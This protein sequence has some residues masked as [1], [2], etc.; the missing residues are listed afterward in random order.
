MFL[1]AVA[2]WVLELIIIVPTGLLGAMQNSAARS[3]PGS[4]G[5]W[6]IFSLLAPAQLG[7]F[8]LLGIALSGGMY[9][10]LGGILKMALKQVRGEEI[11]LADILSV[12]DVAMPL[13]VSGLIISIVGSLAMQVFVLPGIVVYALLMFT[14]LLIVDQ[15]LGAIDAIKA[16]V[17]MLKSQWLM[18]SVFFFVSYLVACLGAILCGI[19]MLATFPVFLIS[20]AYGYWTFTGSTMSV[21]GQPNYGVAQPGVWPPPPGAGNAASFG[22][23]GAGPA[24]GQTPSAPASTPDQTG[25]WPPAQPAPEP[26]QQQPGAWPPTQ[27]GAPAEPPAAPSP[28]EWPAQ[29]TP[30]P[31]GQTPPEDPNR[32]LGGS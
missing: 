30:P 28:S 4:M 8:F 20:I 16:S 21:A 25:A 18:A 27:S 12:G 9:I 17:D 2:V 26:P 32:P 29:T 3:N 31:F 19:G 24:F 13:F 11:A 1:F 15:K 23:T 7:V 6:A 5:P 14:P 10:V 22:Q